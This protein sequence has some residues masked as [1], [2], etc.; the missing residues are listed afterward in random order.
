MNDFN[1]SSEV[2]A[3]NIIENK[4]LVPQGLRYS[5]LERKKEPKMNIIFL[6]KVITFF[7]FT[8]TNLKTQKSH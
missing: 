8:V 3:S 4:H 5:E 1:N 7:F 2:P 6:C